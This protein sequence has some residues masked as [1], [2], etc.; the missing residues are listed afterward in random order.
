[1]N[2]NSYTIQNGDTLG[3]LAS[4]YGTDVNTLASLNGISNPNLIVAGQSLKLPGQSAPTAPVNTN[5][6]I[7]D[8]FIPDHSSDPLYSSSQDIF[9]KQIRGEDIV[10][11]AKLRSDKIAGMQDRIN[12][13]NAVYADQLARVKKV[14]EGNIG[15]GTAILANRGLAG[16]MRGEAI[17]Q[18]ITDTNTQNENSVDT[19]KTN[20]LNTLYE[21]VD[22]Q[23]AQE[24]QQKRESMLSGAKNYIEY[25]KG[26]DARKEKNINDIAA[27]YVTMGLNP[28]SDG[29]LNDIAKRIGVSSDNIVSAYKKAKAIS[30]AEKAKEAAKNAGAPKIQSINGVD[31]Q[32]DGKKWIVPDTG[33]VSNGLSI[34]P[35]VKPTGKAD[36][37]SAGFANRAKESVGILADVEENNTGIV[38]GIFSGGQGRASNRLKTTARQRYEQAQRNFLT[39]V[40]RKESG[41]TISTEE[42]ANGN[43]QYFAQP[44]DDNKTILQKQRNRIDALNSL[45]GSAGQAYGDVYASKPSAFKNAS[46]T[47]TSADNRNLGTSSQLQPGEILVKDA[48]GN[49]G[50]ILESEFDPSLYTKI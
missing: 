23:V 48:Q 21:A 35:G 22:N 43:M 11:T 49:I 28:L 12:G 19:A 2:P 26:E 32:W 7:S 30:D 4:K 38:R 13:L 42:Q 6:P 3:A 44:G 10:D 47:E 17:K 45:I 46:F 50:A 5:S 25:I 8:L 37:V 41:A 36:F 9:G 20:A 1:M 18:G 31:M 34:K 33:T 29:G 15:S 40:L 16:S 39:A 27:S 14:S 24:A